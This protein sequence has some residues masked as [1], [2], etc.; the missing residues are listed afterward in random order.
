MSVFTTEHRPGAPGR[1]AVVFMSAL[2]AGSWIW[3][4]PM[5]AVAE[6]GW[7]VLRTKEPICGVDRRVAGSIE[8]LGDELLAACDEAGETANGVVVC[9]NSLGGLVAID[10]AAR[11][12]ER[13]R[14]IVVS[15]APGLTAD[16]DVGLSMDRRGS[17]S[18]N[19]EFRDLMLS[20]LFYGD[21]LF[22]EEQIRLTADLLS[23]G[24]AMVAMARSLR[25]TRSYQ[26]AASLGKVDCP[27]LFVW[28]QDDQMTPIDAWQELV[29]T[30]ERTQMVPVAECGH[31]PMVERPDVYDAELLAFL[32]R[33]SR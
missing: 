2:F 6:Q 13:V 21:P 20:A 32:D 33:V 29:P 8:R 17:V 15:G 18:L 10:L 19:D 3:D 25:A 22:T 1:P 5:A 28:G 7:P 23:T 16:P 11:Y 27:S 30:F 26:V 14:G 12:P 9:A 4:A 31:I 24:E